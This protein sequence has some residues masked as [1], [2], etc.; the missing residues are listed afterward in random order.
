MQIP[1]VV[2]QTL[3]DSEHLDSRA[4]KEK[5]RKMEKRQS[6]NGSPAASL[7]MTHVLK[8]FFSELNCAFHVNE[9]ERWN[10]T[11]VGREPQVVAH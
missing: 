10:A 1:R 5:E 6:T 2:A 7:L 9:H 4:L 3:S 8:R 11:W